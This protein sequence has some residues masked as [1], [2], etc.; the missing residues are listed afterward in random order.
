MFVS[1]GAHL[2]RADEIA[3]GLIQPGQS[4]YQEVVLYFGAG[5][6]DPDGTIDRKRLADSAFGGA[7][8]GHTNP[9]NKT[10][11]DKAISRIE[12]LNRLIHPEVVRRQNEWME[13]VGRQDPH[14]IAIVE[15]ALILE[16][17][18]A[19][20]FDRL[21]VITCR[22]EQRI[23]RWARRMKVDLET[24]RG[25]VSRRMAAQIPEE[26]KIKTADF[27]IDNS[28]SVADTE[29]QVRKL[30]QIFRQEA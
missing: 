4:V 14:A 25:E 18:A 15:A 20:D 7:D 10:N 11:K 21:V 22:P 8:S 19:K 23:E 6:L 12:E 27:V 1:L 24:A 26:E 2:I 17:G 28:G 3:H 9:G 5:I 30:Y 16:A 13:N 29:T